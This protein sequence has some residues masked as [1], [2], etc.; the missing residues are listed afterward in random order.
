VTNA[1]D[2]LDREG[3]TVMR[4]RSGAGNMKKKTRGAYTWW[5]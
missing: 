2:R 1:D 4:S 5:K 3:W